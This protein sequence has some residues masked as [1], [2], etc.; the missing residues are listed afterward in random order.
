MEFFSSF[1]VDIYS[2]GVIFFEMCYPPLQTGM[3]RIKILSDL[4]SSAVKLPSDFDESLMMQQAF[5]VRWMLNHDP[6]KRPNSQ[7]LLQS[8]YLPPPQVRWK[9]KGSLKDI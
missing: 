1:Q 7:E 9:S 5:I 3:E 2:L 8:D 6:T 4:R